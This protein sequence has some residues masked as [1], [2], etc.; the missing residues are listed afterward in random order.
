MKVKK[1]FS[2]VGKPE[3]KFDLFQV[4][5]I[6]LQKCRPYV[7]NLIPLLSKIARRKEESVQETLAESIPKIFDILGLTN[8]RH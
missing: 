3:A 6:R 8:L 4:P 5:Q 2:F 7:V 1:L